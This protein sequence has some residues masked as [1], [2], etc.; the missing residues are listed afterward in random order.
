MPLSSFSPSFFSTPF[1]SKCSSCLFICSVKSAFFFTFYMLI[2]GMV[3]SLVLSLSCWASCHNLWFLA[4]G[5]SECFPEWQKLK[6]RFHW[7]ILPN[8][9]RWINSE[10]KKR[11]KHF[12]FPWNQHYTDT[13]FTLLKKKE[14]ENY[15][16]LSL[17]NTNAKIFNK[18]NK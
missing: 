3:L 6:F 11:K 12:H 7:W 14:K 5:C 18:I 10:K 9:E 2:D 13:K 8:T 1:I 16:L 15:R 17:K 4:D